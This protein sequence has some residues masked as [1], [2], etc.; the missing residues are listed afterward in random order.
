MEEFKARLGYM[1]SLRSA[2]A[3]LGAGLGLVSTQ[4]NK[5]QS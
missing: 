2:S 4:I 3:R 1:V 5:Q